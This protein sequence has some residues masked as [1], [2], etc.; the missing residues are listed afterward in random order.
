MKGILT[1]MGDGS[2]VWLTKEEL[3]HELEEG[4][5][6][7]ADRGKIP[8][9][10]QGELECLYEICASPR[11]IVSVKQGDEVVHSFDA[12]T[13]KFPLRGGVPVD[14]LGTVLAHERSFCSDT[15]EVGHVDYSFK[16]L[17]PIVHEERQVMEQILLNA[18][19]PVF[20]GAMPNLG[21]YTKPDGPIDNWSELLPQGK[22]KESRE[23]QEEA[24]GHAVKDMVFVSSTMHEAGS[25]GIN[26]DTVGAS[27]DADFLAALKAVEQLKKDH[28][29]IR[30]ELG[31]AGEFVLGMHGDLKYDG[32]RLAGLYPHLQVKVAE[33]AGVDIFGPVVNTKSN[34][35]VP[36][37]IARACTFTKACSEASEIP[38]HPNAGMGVGGVPLTSTAPLDAI[39]RASVA[40]IEIGKADGL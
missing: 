18:T 19:L 14:R 30:V 25:D 40:L 2:I 4:T 9:L 3:R 16:P 33:K 8:P 1:R 28:P 11:K 39:S 38:I 7:A 34:K 22:V 20:Y 6:D 36:W 31:M 5:L 15:I 24:V 23:A 12:G 21:L 35:T 29:D 26:F 17:K 27:G 13:L 10:D 32:T 37:N